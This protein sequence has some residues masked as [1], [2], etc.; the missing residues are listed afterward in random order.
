MVDGWPARAAAWRGVSVES[1]PAPQLRLPGTPRVVNHGWQ[2]R[3]WAVVAASPSVMEMASAE[4][5]PSVSKPDQSMDTGASVEVEEAMMTTILNPEQLRSSQKVH[6]DQRK[7]ALG[8]SWQS[9]AQKVV[10]RARRCHGP[11]KHH[12]GEVTGPPWQE[13]NALAPERFPSP[14]LSASQIPRQLRS[15]GDVGHGHGLSIPKAADSTTLQ[16]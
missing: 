1:R 7:E 2:V 14:R 5:R 11:L 4:E 13:H 15:L 8:Q 9:C 10:S 6:D 16:W 12:G 3:R